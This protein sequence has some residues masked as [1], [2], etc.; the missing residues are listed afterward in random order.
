MI[1]FVHVFLFRVQSLLMCCKNRRMSISIFW[2]TC[3]AACKESFT[4][5]VKTVLLATY[6]D[7]RR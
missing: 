3:T 2:T 5:L 7:D 4:L 6:Y 1:E